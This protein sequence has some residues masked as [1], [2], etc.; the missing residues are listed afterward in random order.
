MNRKSKPQD[1]DGLNVQVGLS[2]KFNYATINTGTSS[3]ILTSIGSSNRSNPA[4]A[5]TIEMRRQQ[6]EQAI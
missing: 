5:K 1:I 6:A 4:D 3:N 2:K